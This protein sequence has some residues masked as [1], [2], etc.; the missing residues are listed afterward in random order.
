MTVTII[1]PREQRAVSAARLI[2]KCT[3]FKTNLLLLSSPYSIRSTVPID[4]FRAFVS[5]LEDGA[6][7]ITNANLASLS[8]LC[9]EFGFAALTARLSEFRCS[10]AYAGKT[11]D[12]EVL[13]RIVALEERALERD[14]ETA[15]LQ[16]ELTRLSA[17]VDS[18]RAELEISEAQAQALRGDQARIESSIARL[19]V[20]V[21]SLDDSCAE[22]ARVLQANREQSEA[23]ATQ[24][25]HVVE[26]LLGLAESGRADARSLRADHERIEEDTARVCSAL[27]ELRADVFELKARPA[28]PSAV[29]PDEPLAEEEQEIEGRMVDFAVELLPMNGEEEEDAI[30]APPEVFEEEEAAVEAPPVD[31]EEEEDAIEAPPVDGEEAGLLEPQPIFEEEEEAIEAPPVDGEEAGL[32]EPQPIFEEEEEILDLFYRFNSSYD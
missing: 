18:L 13:A 1:H 22:Q 14:R 25:W 5:A 15:A 9:T 12:V 10:A 7:E 16:S 29:P 19:S 6:V 23:G 31:G 4:V 11:A 17:A 26:S 8:L 27:E 28:V 20:D 2:D 24:L 32:L 30:E 3:L 21:E